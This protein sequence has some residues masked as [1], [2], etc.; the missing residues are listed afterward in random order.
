MDWSRVSSDYEFAFTKGQEDVTNLLRTLPA[1][2]LVQMAYFAQ[3]HRAEDRLFWIFEA[4]LDSYGP[5]AEGVNLC[6]EEHPPLAYV[7]LKKVLDIESPDIDGDAKARLG[8]S[9]LRQVIRSANELG[10]AALVALEKLRG[11]IEDLDVPHFVNLLWLACN[12]VRAP[13]LVQELLLV[14]TD[15]RENVRNRSAMQ[16][17]LHQHV[18][19]VIF[20][21]VEDAADTCPCDDS[22]RPK[23]QRTAP[24]AGKLVVMREPGSENENQP[25]NGY[26]PTPSRVMAH[27]RVD[28]PSPIRIHTHVRL[29]VSSPAEHSV[30]PAAVVDASVIRATRGELVLDVQHP[31]PPE[32]EQVNWQLY[33][34]GSM[35]TSKAM[36]D[37]VQKLA[38]D[39]I[40]CCRFNDIITGAAEVDEAERQIIAPRNEEDLSALNAG[41][42]AAVA[43]AQMGT[44]CL[45][46]GPPGEH[47]CFLSIDWCSFN[48]TPD[49]GTG[50]TTVVI[51]IL[52]KF[53]REDA[54]NRILMTASTHNGKQLYCMSQ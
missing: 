35:A 41:Q 50:K 26:G 6:M 42:R 53:L 45:I 29:R 34:A 8:I 20:D 28:L 47:L 40:E 23:K 7:I 30:L 12:S 31:L 4:L 2:T 1:D 49:K 27:V 14:L 46:W 24:V 51:Q 54:E 16:A 19:G 44:M 11:Y 39:G 37:A 36:L 33:N 32:F 17:Y 25:T 21:R 13:Q 43:S 18:L 10:I 9:V 5:H 38:I 48:V 15:C 52:L 3:N 22:G